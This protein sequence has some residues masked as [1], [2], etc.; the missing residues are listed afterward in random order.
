M[1]LFWQLRLTIL[2]ITLISFTG[3]LVIGLFASQGYLEQQLHR[4]NIDS[5]DSLAYSISHLNTDP[6][7]IDVQVAAL[8]DSGQSERIA[9]S[10]LEGVVISERTQEAEETGIPDWFVGLYPI[11]VQPATAQIS[12]AWMHYGMVSVAGNTRFGHQVLWDQAESLLLWLL[13]G[14]IG[15][16]LAGMLILL[17]VN[18]PLG[19]MMEQAHAIMDRNFLTISEPHVSELRS[20][21]RARAAKRSPKS[22]PSRMRGKPGQNRRPPR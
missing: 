2:L 4:K 10:S 20:I 13:V 9:V 16:A 11:S 8:F 18:R 19:A 1:S 3:S 15:C 7:I 14:S 5:A 21:A 6:A 17:R 22:A 12:D